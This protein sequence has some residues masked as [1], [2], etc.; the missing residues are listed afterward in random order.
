MKPLKRLESRL[1]R[2]H[3]ASARFSGVLM[4]ALQNKS[5][6]QAGRI[7]IF[8]NLASCRRVSAGQDARLYGR[9]GRLPL[10]FLRH[11]LS[12]PPSVLLRTGTARK[13]PCLACHSAG[14]LLVAEPFAIDA[15]I[16]PS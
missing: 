5:F 11:A 1:A 4:K 16:R 3:P 15:S 8:E 12:F 6:S 2:F 10:H 13:L 14:C 7:S 9:R